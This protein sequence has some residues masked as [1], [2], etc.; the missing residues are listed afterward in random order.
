MRADDV[1]A[2]CRGLAGR[3]RARTSKPETLLAARSAARRP[4]LRHAYDRA[5]ACDPARRR[6][7]RRRRDRAAILLERRRRRRRPDDD[8]RAAGAARRPRPA[9]ESRASGADRARHLQA[10]RARRRVRPRRA[11]CSRPQS[12]F[13]SSPRQQEN[14]STG[15][16]FVIDDKGHI[17][18]NA[19]VVGRLDRRAGVVR[20]QPQ[21]RRREVVGKDPRH[22][23]ALLKVEPEG[24][25]PPPARAR[26]LRQGR[27][28]RRPDR[29]D[30]QPVRARP[31]AD[32][33]RRLGAAAPDHGARRLRDRGRHPDRR[34]DQPRQLGRPADRRRPGA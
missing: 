27:P 13:E 16:G 6:R 33:R 7:P 10:R 31:H 4:S 26:R 5:C 21:G 11:R 24:P 23:L 18:T 2:A 12:P 9:S 30:R 14:V 3:A 15:S 8:D 1:E 25:R 19:H 32:H 28:G 20:R 34:G 17:L 29:R 22:D